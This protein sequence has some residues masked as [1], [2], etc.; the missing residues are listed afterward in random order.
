MDV[1]L[2]MSPERVMPEAEDEEQGLGPGVGLGVGLGLGLGPG[3]GPGPAQWSSEDE[4]D[5]PGPGPEPEPEPGVEE[6]EEEEGEGEAVPAATATAA[7]AAGYQYLPLSQEAAAGSEQDIEERLQELRL[8]L[9]E[10]PVNSDAE[11]DAEEHGSQHS[12]PMDPEHVEL[13]KRTMAA[14]KFPSLG[15]PV[16]AQEISDEQWQS[17]VQQTIESRR[18]LVAAKE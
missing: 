15:V 8:Y 16:W 17:V 10:A 6:E 7:T 2:T 18:S 5:E 13:V 12:I 4:E 1:A 11:E 3:P 14:I 9:P